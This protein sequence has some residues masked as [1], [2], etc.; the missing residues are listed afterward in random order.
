MKIMKTHSTGKNAK[1]K[2]YLFGLWA[3]FIAALYLMLHG[4]RILNMR[5]QTPRGEIDIVAKR[6]DM[7]VFAEVKAR[8]DL[9]TALHSLPYKNRKRIENAALYYIS[10]HR[11]CNELSMRFDFIAVGFPFVIRHLDNAWQAAS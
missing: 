11:G 7:I 4:Y 5:Y 9:S 6:K 8:A 10:S 2:A 1:R 3:E